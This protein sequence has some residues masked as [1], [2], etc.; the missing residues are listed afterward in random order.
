MLSNSALQSC[1][2]A[3]I[4]DHAKPAHCPEN[5]NGT[6][7][8]CTVGRSFGTLHHGSACE[9]PRSGKMIQGRTT[10]RATKK[11]EKKCWHYQKNQSMKSKNDVGHDSSRRAA[12]RHACPLGNNP[13]GMMFF[14]R[15]SGTASDDGRGLQTKNVPAAYPGYTSNMPQARQ[16]MQVEQDAD[17]T[18]KYAE[19][20]NSSFS[21][22]SKY[23]RLCASGTIHPTLQNRRLGS[24]KI[25]EKR[26]GHQDSAI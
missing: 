13:V 20:E 9:Q 15:R 4:A 16:G 21:V 10:F 22:G 23:W 17:V 26:R 1:P 12:H 19:A 5:A 2:V 11:L 7:T 3:E 6:G 25:K 18:R 24:T 14:G 8:Q